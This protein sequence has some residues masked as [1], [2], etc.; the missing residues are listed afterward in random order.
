[1]KERVHLYLD[2]DLVN[3]IDKYKKDNALSSRS[4][5][6]EKILLDFKLGIN[7]YS[8]LES[9]KNKL[10]NKIKRIDINTQILIEVMNS[11]TFNVPGDFK[12]VTTSTFTTHTLKEAISEVEKKYLRD[13][14]N[15]KGILDFDKIRSECLKDNL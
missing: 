1:M 7:S 12:D 8:E 6:V 5:A 2:K 15:Q 3:F 10:D 4:N 14:A 11:I 9:I 13:E